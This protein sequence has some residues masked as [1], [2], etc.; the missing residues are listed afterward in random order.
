MLGGQQMG[1]QQTDQVPQSVADRGSSPSTMGKLTLGGY[2]AD[3][4]EAF[5]P[6]NMLG[7]PL[8]TLGVGKKVTDKLDPVK[9]TKKLI[10][11]LF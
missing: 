1:P 8:A 3:P 10:K 6:K 2:V 11:K 7:N 5:N 4:R 9:N